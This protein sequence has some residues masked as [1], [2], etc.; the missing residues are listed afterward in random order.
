MSKQQRIRVKV[1]L[2]GDSGV[3]K[4]SLIKRL[5]FDDFDE[6]YI[7]TPS[8][9]VQKIVYDFPDSN[10]YE[11]TLETDIWDISGQKGFLRFLKTDFFRKA[12]M[13]LAVC[14]VSRSSTLYN[15]EEWIRE[16]MEVAGNLPVQIVGNKADMPNNVIRY[17]PAVKRLSGQFDASFYFVSAKTGQNVDFAFQEIA[18]TLLENV[19]QNLAEREEMLELEWDMLKVIADKG[20][21]GASKE[22][23]FQSL[24]GVGFDTL[25]ESLDSLESKGHI[26][27]KWSGTSNFLVFITEEGKRKLE[28]G[29]RKFDG[30]S[31]DLVVGSTT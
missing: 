13:I 18:T 31:L 28:E 12:W 26:R 8:T 22:F 15:L 24:R 17:D 29:P 2:V 27:I 4:S 3:G 1:C 5:L 19:L 6:R 23:F 14:D 16:A 20:K 30:E 25:K 10:G 21:L 7:P 9:A 11:I